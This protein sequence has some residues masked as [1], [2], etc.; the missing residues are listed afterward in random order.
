MSRYPALFLC[1]AIFAALQ[2]ASNTYQAMYYA[3]ELSWPSAILTALIVSGVGALGYLAGLLIAGRDFHS[4]T[5]VYIVLLGYF[6]SYSLTRLLESVF[7]SPWVFV[8]GV[9]IVTMAVTVKIGPKWEES[10]NQTRG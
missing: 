2:L 10:V 7:V 3:V 1:A 5:I 9:F 4:R 6:V 8:F